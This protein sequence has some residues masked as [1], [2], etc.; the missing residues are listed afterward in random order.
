MWEGTSEVVGKRETEGVSKGNK[1]RSA[2]GRLIG[3]E[4]ARRKM[5]RFI[6]H[7][8]NFPISKAVNFVKI[9]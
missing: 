3:R 7:T 8:I 4:S 6:G 5:F 2:R 1:R 9:F